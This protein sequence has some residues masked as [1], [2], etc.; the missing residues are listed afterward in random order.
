MTIGDFYV[1][2]LANFTIEDKAAKGLR[3]LLAPQA[4]PRPPVHFSA[5]ELVAQEPILLLTG[6]RGSGKTSFAL[7]LAL[8]LAGAAIGSPHF[9]LARLCH[10][11]PRNEQSAV[12]LEQWMP[13]RVI[14]LYLRA[15]GPTTLRD[16]IAHHWA[17]APGLLTSEAWRAGNARLLI[18]ADEC[19]RLGASGAALLAELVALVERH[20]S[21]RVVALGESGICKSWAVPSGITK[22]ELLPLL[23]AQ[24]RA[25]RP[26]DTA[27]DGGNPG[28][29]MLS[30][31][32]DATPASAHELVDAWLAAA[33]PKESTATRDRIVEAG[34]RRHA[35]LGGFADLAP[36]LGQ[37]LRDSG[38]MV[39]V[40]KPFLLA[41]LAARHLER[42]PIAETIALFHRDTARWAAP[43][44]LLA[45][46]LI[47]Q[48]E[49]VDALLRGLFADS[50][51]AGL[52]GAVLAAA[53]LVETT[54]ADAEHA[55]IAAIRL[56]LLRIVEEGRLCI[57]LREEAGR[58]LARW[59]DPRDLEALA[60]IP[61][62]SFT[63]G[64]A[65]HPNSSPPHSVTLAGFRIGKYPV[66]NLLYLR[67]VA[68]TGRHWPSVD[69]RRAERASTPAADL[70]WH[71]AR[72]Y[73][74]WL[75]AQWRAAGKIGADEQVRLPTEPEWERAARGDQPDRG[76][77][78]LYPWNG[79]WDA[80]RCNSDETGLNDTCTVGLFPRGVSSYGCHDM[81]GQ[82][83]EWGTTLWGADMATPSWRYPYRDDGREDLEA[84]PAIRRVL[85]GGCFSSGK[86]KAC[87]FYRG[88]LEPNGFW[89]GNGFRIVVAENPRGAA[90]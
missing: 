44:R 84:G 19:D 38:A 3:A 76:D 78:I 6:E 4:A 8:H 47:A 43:V 63:M 67:F 31:G 27:A 87:C 30:L 83:W 82:I 75:T 72:A 54:S 18:I 66:T 58:H 65:V 77:T 15:T 41:F 57:S 32:L 33:T 29:F 12:E 5:L 60:D 56:V 23:G 49:P 13:E 73:C 50:G 42:R 52:T 25:Y 85:R 16:L 51:D 46:R 10:R 81:C 21:I 22:R 90:L 35:G 14:P 40:E 59:G 24:R 79:D 62:G 86:E 70:T 9:N 7:H 48:S 28:L 55:L 34:F 68:A 69:G 64:S 1:P 80:D 89:R 20:D 53:V 36:A 71:D 61:G 26:G 88:S 45:Y 17:Q 74:A 39:T 11:V 2:L 37:A